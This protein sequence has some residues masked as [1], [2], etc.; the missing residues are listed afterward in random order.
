MGTIVDTSKKL[1]SPKYRNKN[2]ELEG[3]MQNLLRSLVLTLVL[4]VLSSQASS[5][6]SA[7]ALRELKAYKAA[8]RRAESVGICYECYKGKTLTAQYSVKSAGPP[9]SESCDQPTEDTPSALCPGKCMKMTYS[10]GDV[11]RY[12]MDEA[13]WCDDAVKTLAEEPGLYDPIVD[14]QCTLPVV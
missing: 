5:V 14:I 12:C 7:A 9:F 1:T 13:S 8:L 2:F 10:G 6:R 11:G 3:M 4:C